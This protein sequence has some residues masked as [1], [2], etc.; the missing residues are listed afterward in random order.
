MYI[1]I[2]FIISALVSTVVLAELPNSYGTPTGLI[3]VTAVSGKSKLSLQGTSTSSKSNESLCT[4][5]EFNA[6]T[7]QEV[8]PYLL[9][10]TK[11]CL[12][13]LFTVEGV[14]GRFS[15]SE[16]ITVANAARDAAATYD[17]TQDISN[18]FLYLRSAYFIDFFSPT[19]VDIN[20]TMRSALIESLDAI[21]ATPNFTTTVSEIQNNLQFEW[22]YTVDGS[23]S[24]IAYYDTIKQLLSITDGQ[25][26]EI[27]QIAVTAAMSALFR[28][29]SIDPDNFGAT[30]V[31]LDAEIVT[32]FESIT[33]NDFITDNSLVEYVAN[34]AAA[35]LGRLFRWPN[36]VAGATNS[37]Q[38]VLDDNDRLNVRWLSMVTAIDNHG[39]DCSS[40]TGGNVCKNNELLAEVNAIA[41]PNDFTFDSGSMR[42]HTTLPYDEVEQLYYQLK[43]TQSAFF[44]VT[45]ATTP[46]T[47]D[48]NEVAIFRIYESRTAYT[49]FQTFLYGIGTNNGGIYIERDATLFTYDRESWE[50]IFSLEELARH[51]YGHY[52][53]SRYM[54]PGMWCSGTCDSL[55][56]PLDDGTLYADERLTWFEEGFANFIAGATQSNS[57][58]PLKSM[59]AWIAEQP[60]HYTPSESVSVRYGDPY[61]YPYAQ[62]MFNYLYANKTSAFR[63]LTTILR[64][65]DKAAYD[66]LRA[67]FGNINPTEYN[68]YIV[69]QIGGIS[70]L[71]NPW[72]A[73]PAEQQLQLTNSN[74]I[75]TLI[76]TEFSDL[77]ATIACNDLT[78]IQ[79]KCDATFDYTIVNTTLPL[80]E[81]H[82]AID[83]VVAG[84]MVSSNTN[85]QTVNCHAS[86]LSDTV[87]T[88]RCE[89]GLRNTSTVFN[90]APT[91]SAGS[92]SVRINGT[93]S[94]QM[95]GIDA[96][97][98]SLTFSVTEE[99]SVGVL[100]WNNDGSYTYDAGTFA[101]TATFEFIVN[102][103]E[104]NSTNT[105]IVTITVLPNTPPNSVDVAYS[106]MLDQPVSGS[107]S[108]SD[109]DGDAI[110]YLFVGDPRN[111][112]I[113]FD[114]D[115]GAFTYTST[116]G[117]TGDEVMLYYVNDGR[118]DSGYSTITITVGEVA[119]DP[120][121][122]APTSSGGSVSVVENTS[123]S[124]QMVG[125]DPDGDDIT[126]AATN[127]SNGTLS[128]NAGGSFTYT[129]NTN[130]V[131]TDSFTFTSS[132]GELSSNISTVTITITDDTS[133]NGGSTGGVVT[134]PQAAS[135][136]GGGGS[137]GFGLLILILLPLMRRRV[138]L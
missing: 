59:I 109:P 110:T 38:N 78:N 80:Y 102:D 32:I 128:W 89:G 121:N 115:T 31:G 118:D 107:M 117:F 21:E 53:T 126:F 82:A 39:I 19:L 84:L 13:I 95:I 45:G 138:T 9:S 18:Y 54:V 77:F 64:S 75:Q 36:L 124:G 79:F 1:K 33:T 8:L 52:L 17:G 35:E 7:D 43:E 91:A 97:N 24:W 123:I 57:V 132:D 42:F 12:N 47:G 22:T 27:R 16:F 70:N 104:F 130:F 20:A 66:V 46:V 34:N 10:N 3:P 127:T 119:V 63:D 137:I 26:I 68:N 85:L 134:P 73:Y 74:E 55:G 83:D 44:K 48:P 111:G 11:S 114:P 112:D 2:L 29:Q 87:Q 50:S 37:V 133:N 67:E 25:N 30:V 108:G 131:G 90:S 49:Q 71:V 129:P 92:V 5:D 93:V 105:G 72:K 106:T 116:V 98:D 23:N 58:N 96:E 94:G 69:A 99:P 81:I 62:L 61:M 125:S 51:E 101:T 4:T 113:I 6:L 122:N 14:E 136:E 135:P 76:E 28:G 41:F 86:S 100:S 65:N 120:I 15:Q 56:G 88:L 103:G 60:T 40:F